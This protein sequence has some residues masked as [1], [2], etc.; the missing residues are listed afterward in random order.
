MIE[1]PRI[2]ETEAQAAAVIHITIPRD[3]ISTVMGPA[4][5]EI[6]AAASAQGLSPTGPF[7]AHHLKLSP[8]IFD[9]EVGIPVSATLTPIGRVKPGE[10]PAAKVIRTVYQ[11]AYDGL[12]QAWAEF[13]RLAET[14]LGARIRKEGLTPGATL[15]ERYLVGPESNPDPSMWRTELDQPLITV[16]P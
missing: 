4:I 9:F 11:G 14:E 2:V 15:W 8:E 10:L 13:G 1:T 12:Y 16:D 7:F 6:R 5:Q 3:Q